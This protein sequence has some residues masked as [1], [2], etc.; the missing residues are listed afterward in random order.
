[1]VERRGEVCSR[2]WWV[3]LRERDHL[4]GPGIDGRLMLRWIFRR[5]NGGAWT[6]SC[7][8]RIGTGEGHL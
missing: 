6:G 3:I 4:E 7:W 8:L 5:W 2:F 1:M